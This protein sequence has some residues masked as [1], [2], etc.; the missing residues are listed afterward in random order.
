MKKKEA[1]RKDFNGFEVIPNCN[2][3][4]AYFAKDNGI[5]K[6]IIKKHPFS[7]YFIDTLNCQIRNGIGHLKTVL[8]SEICHCAK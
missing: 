3:L 8:C 4:S 2:Q 1:E 7:D 5:K 6:D